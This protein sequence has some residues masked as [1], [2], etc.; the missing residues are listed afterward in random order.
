MECVETLEY[1]DHYCYYLGCER[2]GIYITIYLI[3]F[4]FHIKLLSRDEM[5]AHSRLRSICLPFH[6]VWSKI[7]LIIKIMWSYL[8]D[9]WSRIQV[10]SI[11]RLAVCYCLN[12]TVSA[13]F[14]SRLPFFIFFFL[15]NCTPNTLTYTHTR[16]N[17]ITLLVYF[18]CLSHPNQKGMHGIFRLVSWPRSAARAN[19]RTN[20]PTNERHSIEIQSKLCFV[21][22]CR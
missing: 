16:T 11:S 10:K 19:E 3:L 18:D 2:V 12:K 8:H 7:G 14:L 4:D 17:N 22:T 13:V 21:Y 5:S 9:Y 6:L 15:L 1:Y 20:E